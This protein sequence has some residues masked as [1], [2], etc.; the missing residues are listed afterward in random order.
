MNYIF[1]CIFCSYE[2]S[3]CASNNQCFSKKEFG[4]DANGTFKLTIAR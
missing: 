4:I 2:A 3:V 1:K